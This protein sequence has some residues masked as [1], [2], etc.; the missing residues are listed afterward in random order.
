MQTGRRP[1]RQAVVCRNNGRMVEVRD[2]MFVG[3][4]CKNR[5]ELLPYPLMT[6]E[7]VR[8]ADMMLRLARKTIV[9]K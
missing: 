6:R 4:Q 5:E 7:C 8:Y 9:M 2:T 3:Y 1:N